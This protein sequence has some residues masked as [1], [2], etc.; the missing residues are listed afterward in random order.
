MAKVKKS[1][2]NS[3]RKR[4]REVSENS[5]LE[6]K[7]KMGENIIVNGAVNINLEV[8][9]TF[10]DSNFRITKANG[11][12]GEISSSC[13]ADDGNFIGMFLAKSS[14][15]VVSVTSIGSGIR[16]FSFDNSAE[17]GSYYDFISDNADWYTYGVI[18]NTSVSESQYYFP[19][20]PSEGD[21]DADGLSDIQEAAQST[22]Q[23]NPDSDSDLVSD[24][25]EVSD[26][27]DP[28]NSSDY[29]VGSRQPVVPS[30]DSDNDGIADTTEGVLG[31]SP[32]DTDTDGDTYSDYDE[33]AAGSDPLD[34]NSIPS[35]NPPAAPVISAI[36][37]DTGESSTDGIT[38]DTNLL[39]NGTAEA[40]SS[41]EVFF[42]GASIGS[43]IATGGTW[44]FDYTGTT[45][46]EGTYS[47]TATATAAG[48]VSPTSSVF[49]AII[50]TTGPVFSS[51]PSGL[52]VVEGTATGS[53][54]SYLLANKPVATD[55]VDGDRSAQ[56]TQTNN[57]TTALLN[58][59]TF[60][61]TY[62]VSDVAGNS[63]S[64]SPIS[65]DVACGFVAGTYDYDTGSY[66]GGFSNVRTNSPELDLSCLAVGETVYTLATR[67]IISDWRGT[68]GVGYTD[69][70]IS[71]GVNRSSDRLVRYAVDYFITGP[72]YIARARYSTT[73]GAPPSGLTTYTSTGDYPNYPSQGYLTAPDG[74]ILAIGITKDSATT[75]TATLE[76][77]VDNGGGSYTFTTEFTFPQSVDMTKTL[78]MRAALANSG[79]NIT[80]VKYVV[81]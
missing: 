76:S 61:V 58:G 63:T 49:T 56:I 11:M 51:L 67:E 12:T 36:V 17:A 34:P 42:G 9:N 28:N 29:N 37:N 65:V 74:T 10:G 39:I 24:G 22:N 7:V 59:S 2:F 6:Q 52:S 73:V 16:Q 53:V 54:D 5:T 33:V 3:S 60:N 64:T 26:G 13:T 8:P 66:T 72:T 48:L 57:Y 27:T 75:G 45:L 14:G 31:T 79:T 41:V 4:T 32:T 43:T 68:W 62:S 55:A 80:N 18:S 77:V 44:S 38:F 25:R 19:S 21:R 46:S 69:D 1:T 81:E 15:G 23:N 30:L 71:T 20:A 70:N 40:D 47:I 35:M 50:D 78:V